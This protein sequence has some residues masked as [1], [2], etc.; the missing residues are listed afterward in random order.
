MHVVEV[1]QILRR[2]ERATALGE[3][4][5]CGFDAVRR[6]RLTDARRD[7][8][9]LMGDRGR[10]RNAEQ[11]AEFVVVEFAR[12]PVVHVVAEPFEQPRAAFDRGT[13]IG[14]PRCRG[15]AREHPD[16]QPPRIAPELVAIRSPRRRR[17]SGITR[18]VAVH[19]IENVRQIP[20]GASNHELGDATAPRFS[21]IGTERDASTRGLEADDATRA[22]RIS[23]RSTTVAGMS[24][25]DHARR[26][27]RRRPTARAAHD[28]IG[29]PRVAS[30]AERLGFGR[31]RKPEL[32]RVGLAGEDE[33]GATKP[34]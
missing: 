11:I 29:V 10:N 34:P 12:I 28:A 20:N 8:V 13:R 22:G 4:P 16:P 9:E 23:D 26:D 15:V 25:R 32:G 30:G 17:G 1:R 31:R 33:S 21:D 2:G 6:N 19:A 24:E 3:Q 7:D 14:R 18:G 27:R 5:R